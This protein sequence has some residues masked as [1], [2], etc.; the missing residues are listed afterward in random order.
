M[1][2]L[3][4]YLS[5]VEIKTKLATLIPFLTGVAYAYYIS[6]TY[7]DQAL[8]LTAY[9]EIDLE[10]TLLLLVTMFP[11][12]M[13]VTAVNNHI[14]KRASKVKAHYSDKASLAIIAV[15]IAVSTALGIYMTY[16]YGVVVLLVGLACYAV[17]IFYTYGPLPIANSAYG[18]I[19][20]G[21]T[22]G[23]LV[24][25]LAVYINFAG[26]GDGYAVY[27]S[28]SF[29]WTEFNSLAQFI[30]Q[31]ANLFDI[32]PLPTVDISLDFH[33]LIKLF[34]VCIPPVCCIANV[35][36]A[37][38]ICDVD[39]DV[40]VRRYTLPYHWGPRNSLRLFKALYV[41][42]EL[43]IVLACLTGVLP[44]TCLLA[45]LTWIVVRKNVA[46]FYER[47]V[48]PDTFALAV[49]NFIMICGANAIL[50]FI[51]SLF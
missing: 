5:F 42:A 23:F 3:K 15:L 12:D 34:L 26:Y 33:E 48:K 43:S 6:I 49:T 16:R 11:F 18:E 27:I 37:N 29:S 51:G 45:P 13:A 30:W 47:Q 21:L 35:M 39:E 41:I 46:A 2:K 40:A 7:W 32:I 25:F 8:G 24:T 36:L 20:S 9:R 31:N 1:E 44:L 10:A 4:N 17:G 28:W 19:F 50:I 14:G 38:N 22:Q